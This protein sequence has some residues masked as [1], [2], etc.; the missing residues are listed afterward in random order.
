[1]EH[2]P[3]VT[4]IIPTYRRATLLARAIEHVRRQTYRNLEIIVVDDGSP[5][6]TGDVV[7]TNAAQDSRI[8]YV[9]H[10]RNKGL[11]AARNTGIRAATG[12][13]IAFID[14]DDEWR[15]DKIERQLR[16]MGDCDAVLCIALS[17]GR[18]LRLHERTDRALSRA[19]VGSAA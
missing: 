8:R 7:R 9:R 1:M 13:Y 17:N 19:F 10:E 15:A 2:E 16:A 6:S 18:P 12:E 3:L 5:D 11:P 4:V 14:D